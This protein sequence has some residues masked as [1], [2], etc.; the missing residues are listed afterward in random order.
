MSL[1]CAFSEQHC[2]ASSGVKK[3]Q[4]KNSTHLNGSVRVSKPQN[5]R[6]KVQVSPVL[7]LFIHKMHYILLGTACLLRPHT[8]FL[9]SRYSAAVA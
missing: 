9:C 7:A 8:T 4:K 5:Q 6:N 3:K 1:E 2:V